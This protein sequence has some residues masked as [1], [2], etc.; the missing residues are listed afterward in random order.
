MTYE[1]I[2]RRFKLLQKFKGELSFT[3]MQNKSIYMICAINL[4]F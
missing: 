2:N 1:N 3:K 4:L